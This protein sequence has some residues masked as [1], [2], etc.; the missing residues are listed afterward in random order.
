MSKFFLFLLLALSVSCSQDKLPK[1]SEISGLRIL[2]V[3]ASSPE[4]AAGATINIQALVSD[5]SETTSM[6][7]YARACIDPG[8]SLGAAAS[9]SGV[10]GTVELTSGAFQNVTTIGS[11]QNFTGLTDAISITVPSSA[12][13]FA[14]RSNR[15]QFN[16][17]NY[18]IEYQ[19]R[20]SRG[21]SI[22]GIKRIVVVNTALRATL[23]TN[24]TITAIQ[25]DAS[26]MTN[27]VAYLGQKPKL[28]SVVSGT[29]SYQIQNVDSSYTNKT[30]DLTTSWFI[31]DGELQYQRTTA[32]TTTEWKAPESAPSG[33]KSWVIAVVYDGRGGVAVRTVSSP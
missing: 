10:P 4:V 20:N 3:V 22:T 1:A 29:E 25:A 17:I 21:Q 30:E 33:R 18:V 15:D 9:C 7:Q 8:I 16:G 19:I 26:T 2:A 11:A 32:T 6:Q 13:M 14:G 27:P 31:S 5:F 28:S 24:P 23:N 12:L